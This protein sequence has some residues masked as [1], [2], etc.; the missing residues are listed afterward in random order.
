MRS[1]PLRFMSLASLKSERFLGFL[2]TNSI[3]SSS[4]N[5][6]RGAHGE[7]LSATCGR[8]RPGRVSADRENLLSYCSSFQS[9]PSPC[10]RWT[11]FAIHTFVVSALLLKETPRY[12]HCRNCDEFVA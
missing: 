4:H 11:S 1:E 8:F 9:F 7:D 6:Y 10:I 2:G 5:E 12:N 3:S